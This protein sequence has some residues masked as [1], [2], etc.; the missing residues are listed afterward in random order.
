MKR[1]LI[2]AV[3]SLVCLTAGTDVRGKS[4]KGLVS[5]N[6]AASV[7]PSLNGVGHI[8]AAA[9]K[10]FA[11]DK[12][13]DSVT[14]TVSGIRYRTAVSEKGCTVIMPAPEQKTVMY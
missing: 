12:K 14:V 5:G 10:A 1:T 8:L 2:L 13:A 6:E 3:I 7:L 4:T 9:G 11:N